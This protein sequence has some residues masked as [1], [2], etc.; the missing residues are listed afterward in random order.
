MSN[1]S[2]ANFNSEEYCIYSS[3]W[4]ACENDPLGI[5][6]QRVIMKE[7]CSNMPQGS[8]LRQILL[9]ILLMILMLGTNG[10]LIKF[11]EDIKLKISP[12]LIQGRK[13]TNYERLPEEGIMGQI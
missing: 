10:I 4:K 3:L 13:K 2:K 1:S 6:S 11:V 9:N 5:I 12:N 8:I 7:I